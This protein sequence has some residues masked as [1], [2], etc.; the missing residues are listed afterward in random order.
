MAIASAEERGRWTLLAE[1]M[2]HVQRTATVGASRER[3]CQSA[4]GFVWW[5]IDLTGGLVEVAVAT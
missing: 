1:A 4:R 2:N 3:R 5:L